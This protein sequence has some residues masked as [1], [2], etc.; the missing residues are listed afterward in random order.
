MDLHASRCDCCGLPIAGNENECLRCGYPMEHSKEKAFLTGAIR[1]LARVAAHGGAAITVSALL[2][3]YQRRLDYLASLDVQNQ[4]QPAGRSASTVTTSTR[5]VEVKQPVVPVASQQVPSA[6]QPIKP[7]VPQ[8][9]F[10]FH[11]FFADQSINIVASLGAFLILVG[12]L[13]FI[14]TT[15]DRLMAFLVLLGVHIFFGATGA[16]T[17][18][19]P[20]VRTVA[21]IYTAIFALQ[22]PLLGFS[23]YRLISQGQL[24]SSTLI[25]ISAAYA[26]LAY[27]SLAIYQ[28]FKPFGYLAAVALAITDLAVASALQLSFWWWPGAFLLL[29]FPLLCFV[30]RPGSPKLYNER[31]EILRLPGLALMYSAVLGTL[32]LG[33]LLDATSFLVHQAFHNVIEFEGRLSMTMYALLLLAWV[34]LFIWRSQRYGG[35]RL[36]PYLFLAFVFSLLYTSLASTVGYML[37]MTLV[38]ALYWWVARISAQRSW[39]IKSMNLQLDVLVLILVLLTAYNSDPN[40]LVQM[41]VRAYG[42]PHFI[43]MPSTFEIDGWWPIKLCSVV[44]GSI[45]LFGVVVNHV[46]WQKVPERFVALW[47]WL[48]LLSGLLLHIVQIQLLLWTNSSLIWG[49]CIFAIGWAVVAAL[50]QRQASGPWAYPLAVLALWIACESLFL[51]FG[52]PSGSVVLLLLLYVFTSYVLALYMK[53]DNWLL[54][55]VGFALISLFALVHQPLPFL[56]LGL[57]MPLL[58][59]GCAHWEKLHQPVRVNGATLVN[60]TWPLYLLG[61]LYSVAFAFYDYNAPQHALAA[62]I[63]LPG[64]LSIEMAMLALTWYAAAVIERE[65][66]L[67]GV[68]TALAVLSMSIPT[69]QFWW[70]AGI[71]I[72]VLLLAAVIS[73]VFSLKWALPWYVVAISA[74]LAMEIQA[75]GQGWSQAA[76]W[77]LLGF[78]VLTYLA[79]V[80]ERNELLQL[81]LLWTFAVL[82]CW[83]V[84]AAG[85]V[86]D[87]YRPPLLT[88][89]FA[90]VGL[91]IR[92]VRFGFEETTGKQRILQVRH[93]LP[94]YATAIFGAV[95]TGVQGLL[96]GVNAPFYAAVPLLLFVFALTAYGISLLERRKQG[97]WLVALFAFWGVLLLPS[98]VNCSS[99]VVLPAIGNVSCQMQTQ[100]ALFA[101]ASSVLLCSALGV[102]VLRLL[103]LLAGSSLQAWGWIWYIIALGSMIST[104]IWCETQGAV[105]PL[106]LLLLTLSM[107]TVLAVII[108]L[109]ER[110]P[111]LIILATLLAAWTI[112]HLVIG[113]WNQLGLLCLLFCLVFASQFGWRLLVPGNAL[114]PADLLTSGVALIGQLLVVLC[115]FVLMVNGGQASHIGAGS[116]AVFAGLILWWG[117]LQH[118]LPRQKLLRYIAGFLCS[119]A[120]SWELYTL[121]QTE[122]TILCTTPAVYLIIISPFIGRDVQ[123]QQHQILGQICSIVGAMLLLGPTLW[124]SFQHTNVGPSLLLAGESITLLL[125]GFITRIR[126]FVLSSAALVIVTAIHVLF[127]P[128]LGIPTFLALFLLGILLV[129]LATTLLLVRPRL[130]AFWANAE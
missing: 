98:I 55:P 100:L 94:V 28:R 5:P 72:G 32:V 33:G 123:L 56:G 59:A 14:A 26:T 1:D 109:M 91:G 103:K 11:A 17:F 61:L 126:F 46:G 127:L 120:V 44:I 128:S 42:S 6:N 49:L 114:I 124:L 18:R 86:G 102:V 101:L 95:L 104:C 4:E 108:M 24:S 9:A 122:P 119:L 13:S 92:Y 35:A 7:A 67:L 8:R 10:S 78:A 29:A 53:L 68:A 45:A 74:A 81:I 113:Q 20:H 66:W 107:F 77:V 21:I 48:L 41:F 70:L 115:S 89:A 12:S 58:A 76:S 30:N 97:L 111:E 121:G 2:S 85:L 50:V 23:F 27:S 93:V 34:C 129:V 110:V 40:L 90:G 60:R 52:L 22:I 63:S 47:C 73:R 105:I 31:L 106:S 118:D 64:L 125:L 96:H 83:A 54:L 62:W 87:L 15:P 116:L 36:L 25:A 3:R 39:P 82:A 75:G 130:A 38:A 88:L 112:L 69:N 57:L 80:A 84:Y 79:G 16:I 43:D 71:A 117:Q 37:V 65:G 19:F 51:C 99:I